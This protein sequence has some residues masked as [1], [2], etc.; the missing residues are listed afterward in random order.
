MFNFGFSHASESAINETS[1]AE[2]STLGGMDFTCDGIISNDVMSFDLNKTS[3]QDTLDDYNDWDKLY[4][5]YRH[6]NYQGGVF[7]AA[8]VNLSSVISPSGLPGNTTMMMTQDQ[9]VASQNVTDD[10]VIEEEIPA[11]FL[12]EL[13]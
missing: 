11:D 8:P 7:Q 13:K 10:G 5:Y 4:L 3:T 9:T 2:T 12:N 1:L 6:L